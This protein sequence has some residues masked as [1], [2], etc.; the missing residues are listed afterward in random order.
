MAYRPWTGERMS[1]SWLAALDLLEA[2]SKSWSVLAVAMAE[3]GG[4]TYQSAS[5]QLWAAS[6]AGAVKVTGKYV[7]RGKK[8]GRTVRLGNEAEWCERPERYRCDVCGKTG[9]R[10]LAEVK[11]GL[12]G[13]MCDQHADQAIKKG[14][15]REI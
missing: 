10:K 12:V 2:G 8:D 4:I 5:K 14:L 6:K 13:K 7:Q 9:L 1:L 15:A 3:R 11:S